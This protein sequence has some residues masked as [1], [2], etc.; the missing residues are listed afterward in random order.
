MRGGNRGE[1]RGCGNPLLWVETEHGRPMPL[2]PDPVPGG[3]VVIDASG[4]AI[5]FARAGQAPKR[6]DRYVPHAK[7]CPAAGASRRRGR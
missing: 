7:T 6:F 4:V 3:N 2:D 1:C 5:V